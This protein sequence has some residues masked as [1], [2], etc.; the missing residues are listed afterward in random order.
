M[1]VRSSVKKMCEFCRTVKRRGRVYVLCTANPKHKQR[2]GMSTFANEAPSH[3]VSSEISSHK[4]EIVRSTHSL[5]TGLASLIP[6]RHSLAMLYGWR[7]GLA[8][9][10]SKK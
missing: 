2:Q 10:M 3:P 7:L 8:S 1:K 6:Q 9:I 4:Q 5:R